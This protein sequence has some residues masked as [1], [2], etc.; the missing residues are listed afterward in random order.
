MVFVISLA[1]AFGI[2]VGIRTLTKVYIENVYLS[3]N[4]RKERMDGYFDNLQKY[5]NNNQITEEN[6]DKKIA[7]WAKEHKY[8][9]LLINGTNKIFWVNSEDKCEHQDDNEDGKCDK[10]ENEIT[11]DEGDGDNDGENSEN[12]NTG[13]G[14]TVS[15]PS[16]DKLIEDAQGS[17]DYV[18]QWY[19]TKKTE[20]NNTEGEPVLTETRVSF[21][22]Y[23]EYL[24]YDI[25]NIASVI[26]AAIAVSV[27]M[28]LYIRVV[29]KRIIKLGDTVN[30]VASGEV[31]KHITDGGKDEIATLAS[32]VESMR[33]TMV[34]NYKKE[35]EAL[36]SNTE[37]IT[38]MSHDIRTP[39]TVLLGYI[40]VMRLHSEEDEVMQGYLRAAESTAMRLK[41]LSDDMFGYF[42]VFGGKDE[43]VP[44]EK[45]DA[46]TLV[47]QML[48]EHILLMKEKGYEIEVEQGGEMKEG[49]TV[50]TN[51]ACL[52]RIFDNAFS[53]IN[54]YA[55]KEMPV[56]IQIEADACNIKFVFSNNIRRD[57]EKVESNG[58]GL[59]TCAKLAEMIG[60]G[61]NTEMG[62]EIFSF[63]LELPFDKE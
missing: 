26:I 22:D 19:G 56:K 48:S 46:A 10:C 8:V 7:E 44:L 58:I 13:S 21:A 51:A 14:I 40:D 29:T 17:G 50:S 23:S 20:N 38:S 18:L 6:S 12:G 55:D 34:E 39:L 45:Y 62:D 5:V 30:S 41:K 57:S 9:I 11:P 25:S 27:I 42:L 43:P 54:K 60:A 52:L 36:K 4:N 59:K 61:F 53:N 3:E 49:A 15:Y 2:F 32:N 28:L 35:K 1:I 63:E 24:Y 31:E 37:L 33:S 47:D 16:L